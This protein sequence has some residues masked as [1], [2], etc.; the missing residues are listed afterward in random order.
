MRL[1]RHIKSANADIEDRLSDLAVVYLLKRG[2]D[3]CS[4]IEDVEGGHLTGERINE[5]L[6]SVNPIHRDPKRVSRSLSFD[7]AN[8]ATCAQ[9]VIKEKKPFRDDGF[10][11]KLT[12]WWCTLPVNIDVPG[13]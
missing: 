7:L 6:A 3:D 4:S 8:R 5:F 10:Q 12:K 11:S 2:A 9:P 1:L 13:T